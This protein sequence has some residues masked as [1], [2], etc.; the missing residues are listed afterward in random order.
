MALSKGDYTGSCEWTWIRW[1][2]AIQNRLET[3]RKGR[4]VR[5]LASALSLCLSSS[6]LKLL[7]EAQT[8]L[9]SSGIGQALPSSVWMVPDKTHSAQIRKSI[10]GIQNT[11]RLPSSLPIVNKFFVMVWWWVQGTVCFGDASKDRATGLLL[12]W[13]CSNPWVRHKELGTAWEGQWLERNDWDGFAY[14]NTQSSTHRATWAR[15]PL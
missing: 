10:K 12:H 15:H 1:S 14:V 11:R 7:D 13:G 3:S 8:C 4:E 2:E 6:F 5:A 9:S